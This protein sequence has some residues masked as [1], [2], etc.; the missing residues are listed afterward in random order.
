MEQEIQ[1]LKKNASEKELFFK[2]LE[3][4]KGKQAFTN[5]KLQTEMEVSYGLRTKLTQ[6][7]E[8]HQDKTR[9]QEKDS[10][11]DSQRVEVLEEIKDSEKQHEKEKK[12]PSIWKKFRHRIGLRKRKKKEEKLEEE[13]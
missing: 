7:K 9:E 2:G 1:T 6:L 11:Q 12:E 5:T 3:D 4:L 13:S 8:E 10:F